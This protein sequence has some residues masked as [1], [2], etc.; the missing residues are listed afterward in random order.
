[1]R[2]CSSR[3][4]RSRIRCSVAD[5]GTITPSGAADADPGPAALAGFGAPGVSAS[6]VRAASF[7]C[8]LPADGFDDAGLVACGLID[9]G[10][11]PPDAA[12]SPLRPGSNAGGSGSIVFLSGIG[13]R[14]GSGVRGSVDVTPREFRGRI[15]GVI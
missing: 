8:L 15:C 10:L 3:R 14:N 4:E 6:I 9:C 12:G 13:V 1:M 11:G 5:F 2:S 7:D